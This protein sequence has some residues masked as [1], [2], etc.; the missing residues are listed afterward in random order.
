MPDIDQ[1]AQQLYEALVKLLHKRSSFG[2]LT[3]AGEAREGVAW[4]N[5]APKTRDLFR[6]LAS[7]LTDP[8]PP[9]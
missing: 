5:A 9:P 6:E 3:A 1:R 2:L 4:D 7:N 8:P